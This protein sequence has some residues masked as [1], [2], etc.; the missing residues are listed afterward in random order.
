VHDEFK[1]IIKERLTQ[2]NLIVDISYEHEEYFNSLNRLLL[3]YIEIGAN[4][5]VSIVPLVEEHGELNQE[6]GSSEAQ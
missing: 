1:I 3:S 6:L 5:F 2:H 4:A